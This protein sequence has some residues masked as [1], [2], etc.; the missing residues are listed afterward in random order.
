MRL[1]VYSR[2]SRPRGAMAEIII[3]PIINVDHR[4]MGLHDVI[5]RMMARE[6][7][8]MLVFALLS[9]ASVL[10]AMLLD[11][12]CQQATLMAAATARNQGGGLATYRRARRICL[13]VERR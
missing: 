7:A 6:E 1:I 2:D 12:P 9:D 5:M 3:S 8:A 10:C 4:V 11:R 13:P